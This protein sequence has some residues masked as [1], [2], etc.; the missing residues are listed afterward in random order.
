MSL[1]PN[2][3][4]GEAIDLLSR[5]RDGAVDHATYKERKDH[6]C[7]LFD[8]DPSKKGRAY[9]KGNR[10]KVALIAALVMDAELYLLDEPTSGLDPLMEAVF[11][12]EIRRIVDENGATVLL[13]SHILS[14]V[15]Q[16]AGRVS[17]I[18]AGR[19][20]DGGTL[21]ALRHLTRTEI[22]FA[23]DSVDTHSRSTH[24]PRSTTSPWPTGASNSAPIPIASTRSC[25]F[26]APSGSKACSSHR[27]RSKSCSYATTATRSPRLRAGRGRRRHPPSAP[28]CCSD[29]A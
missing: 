19:I 21:D 29:G 16:L 28:P 27:R 1:W 25:H 24:C 12:R 3:S 22:S 17:I 10:Q 7:E 5:L 14:E 11:T 18:R 9:S 13:S 6:L 26:L 23:Q 8:F 20:D 2:L 15:E 4:G